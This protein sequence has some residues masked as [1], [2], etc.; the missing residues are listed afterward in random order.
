MAL[1]F[2]PDGRTVAVAAGRN[3]GWI[4]LF[5]APT[6]KQLL[7]LPG[8]ESYVHGLAFTPDGRK[9]ASAQNDCT[10]LVWDVSAARRKLPMRDLTRSNLDRLWKQ[11]QDDDAPKAHAALWA[12][13]AAPD[14]TV[15]FLKEHLHPVPHVAAERLRRLIAVLDADDFARREEASHRLTKL[16]I[17]AE[18][19]LRKALESKPS[20]E[21]RRRLE[22]LLTELTC[23]TEMTP[24]SLR[25]L[26]AIQ[27][28]EQIGSPQV[29]PILQ[30]LAQGAP[31]A[32]QTRDA[33]AA[34]A[35]L[36]K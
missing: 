23:Q 35:R 26:R 6:G 1:A 25:Q 29:L 12:L 14:Q 17:E 20:L 31:A 27:V 9:L 16:G 7:R 34:R 13:V 33:A 4:Y 22:T 11:L 18:P 32:P 28:L 8:G 10:A 5:D 15:P 19:A 30:S 36:G 21:M 3:H 24:D 2:A